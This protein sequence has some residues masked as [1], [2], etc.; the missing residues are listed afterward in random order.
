M[1]TLIIEA[2]GARRQTRVEV[3]ESAFVGT[4]VA[5]LVE[6]LGYPRVNLVGHPVSYQLRQVGASGPLPNTVRLA[7]ARIRSGA[8]LVLE[9]EEAN[10]TT[11]PVET[12]GIAA[13]HLVPRAATDRRNRRSF[14]AWTLTSI[15][16][17]GLGS[18]IAT[19]FAQRYLLAR[20]HETGTPTLPSSQMPT[21]T[22]LRGAN[23]KLTFTTHQQTVRA[24][25]WSP[26]GTMLASGSDDGQVLI[27]GPTGNVQQRIAHPASV[28]ALAWS[29]ESQRLVTGA[30][31]QVAFFKA[32]TGTLLASSTHQ[33]V[34]NVSSVAWASNNQ[35]QVATGGID[36]QAFVWETTNYQVQAVFAHHNAAIQAVS[37]GSDGQ[38]VASASQGG[39]TRI[40]N[41]ATAQ[42][43]HGFY[44][45]GQ[46]AM[47]TCAFAPAGT[48]LAVGGNDGVV[49]VWNGF[50]CQQ[51][52]TT[53]DGSVCQD[54]PLR[55]KT[56]NKAIRSLAWSS[57]GHYL[58][59]GSDDGSFTIWSPAQS[60]NP[61]FT[62]TIAGG[63]AVHSITWSSFGDQLATALGNTVI[64]W[65]LHA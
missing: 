57:D 60:Q 51:Q 19:D 26:D 28:V 37:W 7:H 55:L 1:I 47:R 44:Q 49:R 38:I 45:D 33:H 65:K 52:Q 40:W 12:P 56:S 8:H 30:G 59:S 43:I 3:D 53:N 24:L 34:A 9:A 20:S 58:A 54:T 61:L 13:T 35:M 15:S 39:A 62:I 27:W 41:A 22:M 16:L 14:I 2:S 21:T 17:V 5:S 11:V 63:V 6:K 10:Y 46:V 50:L 29:P 32:L 64:L 23:V 31:T 25:G 4:C 42:E 48:S 18:G 36:K